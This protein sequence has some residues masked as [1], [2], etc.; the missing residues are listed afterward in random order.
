MDLLH[1]QE[2]QLVRHAVPLHPLAAHD[3]ALGHILLHR[4]NHVRTS[5]P[6]G[7]AFVDIELVERLVL[8]NRCIDF[9]PALRVLFLFE[10]LCVFCRCPLLPELRFLG[11]RLGALVLFRALVER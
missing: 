3:Q 2:R 11:M 6:Q 1:P 10:Q 9:L 8:A 7:T 5:V 4:P